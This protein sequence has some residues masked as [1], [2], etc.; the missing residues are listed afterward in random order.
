[1]P[2]P[3]KLISSSSYSVFLRTTISWSYVLLKKVN[4]RFSFPC[5]NLDTILAN[6]SV[7]I[8]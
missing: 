4:L 2:E 5:C 3:L 7:M 6:T 1:M 8:N